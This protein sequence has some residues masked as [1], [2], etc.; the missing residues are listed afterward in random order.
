MTNYQYISK[1]QIKNLSKLKIKKDRYE[2]GLYVA[3]GFKLCSELLNI[4]TKHAEIELIIISDKANTEEQSLS[5]SFYDLGIEVQIC[6][7]KGINKMSYTENPQGIL[8]VMK[9]TKGNIDN[10]NSFI[11]ISELNDPGNL[12]TIIR[13][14]DW[15]SVKN[16]VLSSNSVDIYNPKVIRAS[17][18]SFFRVNIIYVDDL[19]AFI[20][21]HY[22]DTQ[23][24]TADS[25]SNTSMFSLRIPDKFGLLFGSE[26]HG[27]TKDLK[28]DRFTLFK[29][30]GNPESDSLNVAISMSIALFYFTRLV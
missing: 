14:A 18:G 10:N 7:E 11:A 29:I 16:I 19:I 12:G 17:M 28:Y 20:E 1:N 24:F 13:S 27:I 23:I 26:S 22:P 4:K 5:E 8:A 6:E 21:D 9:I 25:N 3:E 2:Q 30:D 15:F